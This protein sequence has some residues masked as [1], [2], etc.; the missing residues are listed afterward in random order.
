[1]RLFVAVGFGF[2]FRKNL[3]DVIRSLEER[4][5]MGHITPYENMHL[6][7][8]FLGEVEPSKL[9]DLKKV[10]DTCPLSPFAIDFT[11]IGRFSGREGKDLIWIGTE[12]NSWL[13]RLADSV[14]DSLR[15]GGFSFDSKPFVPHLTIGREIR[16][17]AEWAN[18]PDPK[19]PEM[20][21]WVDRF[22]LMESIRQNGQLRYRPLFVKMSHNE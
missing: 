9:S 21:L 15:R 11:Q 8:A 22:Y 4:M 16:M 1:M 18:H 19:V 7:L 3:G 13:L 10:L 6:T 14:R 17:R 12:P 2:P 20:K 5:E